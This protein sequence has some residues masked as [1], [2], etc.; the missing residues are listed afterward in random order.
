MATV[1]VLSPHNQ[2][3]ERQSAVLRVDRLSTP[4]AHTPR[5]QL[6]P[7]KRKEDAKNSEACAEKEGE[8]KVKFCAKLPGTPPLPTLLFNIRCPYQ[9]KRACMHLI[10]DV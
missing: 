8:N 4:R 7:F 10:T 9:P 1:F 6:S 5:S 3:C 2:T